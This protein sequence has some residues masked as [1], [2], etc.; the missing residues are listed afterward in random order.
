MP[1]T[2]R[3]TV[4]LKQVDTTQRLITGWAAVASNTDRGLDVIEP[5]ALQDAARG[6]PA[7]LGVFIGHNMAA[8]PVGICTAMSFDGKG[9]VTTTKVFP[10]TAGDD[11]LATAKSLMAAG[12]ALGLSIGYR[13]PPGGAAYDRRDG[14]T[15]R[16]LKQLDIV[17]FSFAASQSIM[18]PEALVTGVK[19]TDASKA[20]VGSFGYVSQQV[21]AALRE[22]QQRYCSIVDLFPDRVIYRCFDDGE[23]E[24]LYEA[25]YS[26]AADGEVALGEVTAVDVR[27]VPMP[28]K[29][30]D[31]PPVRAETP[32]RS[33]NVNDLPDSAFLFIESG[34]ALDDAGKTVPRSHRHFAYR[35]AEGKVDLAGLQA[36]L[37]AIPGTAGLDTEAKTTLAARVRRMA[38]QV[39]AG[40]VA[41]DIS[42]E[43]QSGAAVAVRA[44]GYG[45]L[46]ASEQIAGELKAMSLLGSDTKSNG[47]LRPELR[48]K[49][50]DLRDELGRL[51]RHAELIDAEQDGAAQVALNRSRLQL[52]EV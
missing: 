7:K 4:E 43:W 13:V 26:L 35:D 6:D 10:T 45:L 50:A 19:A 52:L 11:L 31:T 21:Q 3:T 46:D 44:I 37:V 15:V 14:K 20:A 12:Q 2:L 16:L 32:A 39:L 24:Q 8:L 41:D 18:N 38:D 33:S 25:S 48:Q 23:T 17:E 34:G 49:L 40:K 29:T 36:A 51:I 28:S 5:K 30:D 22:T 1:D 42:P 9:L 47:R 27:Y